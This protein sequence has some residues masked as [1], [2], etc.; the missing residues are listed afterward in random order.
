LFARADDVRTRTGGRLRE[1]GPDAAPAPARHDREPAAEVERRHAGVLADA[2]VP[3]WSVSH[4]ERV[5]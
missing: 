2:A 1:R 5:E 3:L 4:I